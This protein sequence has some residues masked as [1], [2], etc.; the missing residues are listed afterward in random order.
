VRQ[1]MTV[2]LMV[3][4]TIPG[5]CRPAPSL[6]NRL[7][8]HWIM[9]SGKFVLKGGTMAVLGT[10]YI[11]AS[12]TII[13]EQT[14]RFHREGSE[15]SSPRDLVVKVSFPAPDRMTWQLESAGKLSDWLSFQRIE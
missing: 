11:Y 2:M 14:I 4:L 13:D 10:S 12:Y 1:A 9:G 7:N 8:G 5:G 15:L 3:T 6:E